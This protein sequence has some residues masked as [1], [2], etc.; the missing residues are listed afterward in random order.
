MK[1]TPSCEEIVNFIAGG[2]TPESFQFEHLLIL[3]KARARQH[4]EIAP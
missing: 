4:L 1:P 3:A 2:T